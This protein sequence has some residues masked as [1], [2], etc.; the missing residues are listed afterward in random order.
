MAAVPPLGKALNT[1]LLH[2][3]PVGDDCGRS[4]TLQNKTGRK[5]REKLESERVGLA[6][7][8]SRPDLDSSNM[9]D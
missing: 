9:A 6:F 3:R 2:C 8:R 7:E 4:R 1:Q 5:V